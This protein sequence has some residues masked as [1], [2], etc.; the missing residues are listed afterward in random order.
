MQLCT[1]LVHFKIIFSWIFIRPE[2]LILEGLLAM[3]SL[4]FYHHLAMC[5]ADVHK[6]ALPRALNNSLLG[7]A[8]IMPF[9]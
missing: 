2:G 6:R 9:H 7:S 3:S 8:S 4:K 5:I 1:N